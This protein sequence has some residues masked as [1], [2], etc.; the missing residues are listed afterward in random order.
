MVSSKAVT[1]AEYLATL[2][3]ERKKSMEKVR[4][5]VKKSLPKG[6]QETMQYGMISWVV[7]LSKYPETYNGQPLAVASLAS[8]K[9]YMSLYLMGVY[10]DEKLRK[11]LAQGYRA[12]GKKLDM[13]KSCLRFKSA[14]DLALDV[15]GD[16][17]SKV[18]VDAFI[19]QYED[20][21]RPSARKKKRK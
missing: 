17:V 10:G 5:L 15:I 8:Q 3:E 16:V 13:G 18:P 19:A 1:V 12:S 20:S 9:T 14:D 6:Y 2:P 7:P 21:R 4:R 11:E